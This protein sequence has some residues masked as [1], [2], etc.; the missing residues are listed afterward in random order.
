M[1]YEDNPKLKPESKGIMY[2]EIP[3]ET[4]IG[5]VVTAEF[6][7]G[8]VKNLGEAN[9]TSKKI[10]YS[11]GDDGIEGKGFMYFQEHLAA[12]GKYKHP[13]LSFMYCV[14]T[15]TSDMK[16]VI[17]CPTKKN[18][19][20]VIGKDAYVNVVSMEEFKKTFYKVYPRK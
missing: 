9:Y 14:R 10:V 1:A 4:N 20:G 15:R 13:S 8:T 18:T 16:S 2:I 12:C 7:G 5:T 3:H 11:G 17:E 19:R 6:Y